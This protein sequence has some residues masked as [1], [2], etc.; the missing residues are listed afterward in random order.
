MTSISRPSRREFLRRAAVFASAGGL[1]PTLAPLFL[2]D[3]RLDIVIRGG[4]LIDG[5]GKPAVR[6]DLGI[7]GGRITRIG[8]LGGE[9][10]GRVIDATGLVVAPGFI[11]V[12]AH[13][14]LIGNPRGQSKVYQGVTLDLTGPDG[15]SA[16]PNRVDG[17]GLVTDAGQCSSFRAWKARHGDIAMNIGSYVGHGTVRN[18]VLGPVQ[19]PPTEKELGVMQDLVRQAMEE[20]AIGLSSGLE[21]N[22]AGFAE[23]EEIIALAKVAGEYGR[24]YGTHMRSEDQFLLEST[25]ESIR[26][27][28]ES[29]APLLITHMK[30]GG[31][32]NWDKI[33]ALIELVENARTEG[34]NVHCDRYPYE[35]WST[36]LSIN[37]PGWSKE[38]GRFS[39]RLRDPQERARMKAETLESVESNGGW[40]A[41]MISGGVRGANRSLIG[42]RVDAVA[43]ERDVD[44][45]E[46]ACDLLAAGSVSIIGFGMSEENTERI[47]AL[48]YCMIASD[49]SA[50]VASDNPGGHPRSFGTFP[51][52]IRRYVRERKLVSLE[53]MVRKMTS[54]P[55]A[56]FNLPDRGVL[57]EDK[58]ADVVVF[59]AD[60][61]ADESTYIE[62]RKY[63]T[64]IEY[65]LVNGELAL[66]GG[67]QTEIAAGSVV[68]ATER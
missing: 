46:L 32:P 4:M 21:Y 38:G 11:D 27:C 31:R 7:T 9:A 52:A 16:F 14:N 50:M 29:G 62:P 45:Y 54:L 39:E 66:D 58:I 19:R 41:L 49:G 57:A 60:A 3:K 68:G 48:P 43:K 47:I 55:A 10:A 1:S 20:G 67:R 5:S 35:A 63:A 59:D 2:R 8:Q 51:R 64:G 61:I 33:D 26:I 37:F 17:S 28:R 12:H 42:K 44:T 40:G 30:V 22:P 56:V 65:L 24:P 13:T 18:L 36:S 15:G 53:E 23:T 6:A 34:L 25:E